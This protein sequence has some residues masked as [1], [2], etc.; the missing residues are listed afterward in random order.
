[1]MGCVCFA[2]VF[3]WS[4]CVT[5]SGCQLPLQEIHS[6]VSLSLL[7]TTNVKMSGAKLS[8]LQS[9]A[10][11]GQSMRARTPGRSTESPHHSS[12]WWWVPHCAPHHHQ[13]PIRNFLVFVQCNLDWRP[14][15]LF[16]TTHMCWLGV[17]V[18]SRQVEQTW[19]S[20]Q[21]E[22]PKMCKTMPRGGRRSV[23]GGSWPVS[24]AFINMKPTY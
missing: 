5:A 6:T 15:T 2:A 16:H 8:T 10:V 13:Q 7:E 23:G 12:G 14:W 3:H 22:P 21:P 11:Q 17:L 24:S 1:M 20:S 19:K 9:A 4:L 18:G